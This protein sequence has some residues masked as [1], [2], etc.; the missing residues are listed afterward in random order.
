MNFRSV[1]CKF[2]RIS[3]GSKTRDLRIRKYLNL[4]HGLNNATGFFLGQMN[5][6]DNYCKRYKLTKKRAFN[7]NN[8]QFTFKIYEKYQRI[9]KIAKL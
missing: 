1:T 2:F 5:F 6:C 4:F 9:A 3:D 8:Y 7:L